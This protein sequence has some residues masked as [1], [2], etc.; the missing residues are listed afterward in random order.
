MGGVR[1]D[2]DGKVAFATELIV[3][4]ARVLK[5]REKARYFL[6]WIACTAQLLSRG[7]FCF[8]LPKSNRPANFPCT[9]SKAPDLGIPEVHVPRTR[10][11]QSD[12]VP[13]CLCRG[14]ERRSLA[15]GTSGSSA[16]HLCILSFLYKRL[17]CM[18][19]GI[20]QNIGR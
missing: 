13:K 8:H 3:P 11:T 5:A 4:L 7:I 2:D 19:Q 16:A 14:R 20:V 9:G 18:A 10:A 6:S 1:Q 12:A 15:S 17:T